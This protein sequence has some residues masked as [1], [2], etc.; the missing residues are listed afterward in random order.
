MIV[1]CP[2]CDARISEEADLCPHCG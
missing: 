1:I 2:E